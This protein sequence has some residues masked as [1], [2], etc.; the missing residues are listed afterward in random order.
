MGPC[1][2]LLPH[3]LGDYE[4]RTEDFQLWSVILLMLVRPQTGRVRG[5]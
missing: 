3:V 1:A 5:F 4:E 2:P